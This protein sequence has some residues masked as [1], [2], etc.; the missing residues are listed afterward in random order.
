MTRNLKV[1]G[2]A[3]V[4]AFAMSAMVASAASATDYWF[5]SANSWTV[6]TGSQVGSDQFTTNSGT[7]TCSTTSYTGSQSGTTATTVSLTPTYS[8]CQIS[9]VSATIHTNGCFYEF[10]THTKTAG[11]PTPYHVTT[12]IRCPTT[13]SPSHKTHQIEITVGKPT[14]KCTID[15][16]EQTI[17]TGV[18]LTN[19]AGTPTDI[20]ADISIAT[21]ITYS[22]TTG[23]GAGACTTNDDATNGAYTGVATIKGEDTSA[24]P[25]AISLE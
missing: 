18:T 24:S 20:K 21:G 4:A 22:E 12:T 23:T 16:P 15:V 2:L 10:H 8:G 7:V 9:G 14:V 3:L 13:T 11:T 1:L 19:E 5:K 17:A 6:L 25:V